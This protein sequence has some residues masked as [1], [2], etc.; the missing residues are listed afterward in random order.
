M[1]IDVRYEWQLSRFP[2]HVPRS[3]VIAIVST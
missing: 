3:Q 2:R 1:P